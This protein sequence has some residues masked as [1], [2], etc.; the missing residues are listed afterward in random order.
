MSNNI[1]SNYISALKRIIANYQIKELEIRK[2][3]INKIISFITTEM[4][5]EAVIQYNSLY[6]LPFDTPY[7][8]HLT[9]KQIKLMRLNNRSYWFSE[10][11][12]EY[13]RALINNLTKQKVK[14]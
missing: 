13:Y 9:E 1:F 14:Q 4:T 2:Q 7:H 10:E 6:N 11:E 5:G 3:E 12:L 8:I